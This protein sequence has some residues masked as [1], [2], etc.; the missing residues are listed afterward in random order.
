MREIKTIE[1]DRWVPSEKKGMVKHDGMISPHEA[2]DAL[3][4]HLKETDLMPDEYFSPNTWSWK[5]VKE[6]PE[7]IRA[8]CNVHWGGSEGIYLDVSLLYRDEKSE[9]QHFNLATGKTL[10]ES[11]DDFLR[12]SRIAAECSMMLNGRGE[13]VRF[14]EEEKE[15][16]KENGLS[17]EE[18]AVLYDKACESMNKFADYME[19]MHGWVHTRVRKEFRKYM[20]ECGMS[21]LAKQESLDRKIGAA[22]GQVDKSAEVHKESEKERG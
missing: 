3:E 10:G 5:D 6:L 17:M 16:H 15:V 2:F 13:I 1:V 12:M 18:K 21:V 14:Y 8:D 22:K 9:L 19:S 11:G 7:Y 4:K 20:E